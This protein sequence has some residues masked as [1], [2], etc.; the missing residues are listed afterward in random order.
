HLDAQVVA[1]AL[2]LRVGFDRDDQK[3]IAWRCATQTGIALARDAHAQALARASRDLDLDRARL[4]A[5]RIA[6]GVSAL[7]A[8]ERFLERDLDRLLDVAALTRSR[9]AHAGTARVA[10]EQLL[11]QA[12][13]VFAAFEVEAALAGITRGPRIVPAGAAA[14]EVGA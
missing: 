2:E 9:R 6:N 3:E 11:E 5:L 13:D 12:A 1:V 8:S 4:A 7:G 14:P 10:A